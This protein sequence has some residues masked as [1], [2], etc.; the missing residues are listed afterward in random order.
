MMTSGEV[1]SNSTNP[2][3]DSR[4][5]CEAFEALTPIPSVLL[6]SAFRIVKVSASFLVLNHLTSDECLGANIY[7]L[8]KSRT[9]IPGPA[10]LQLVIDN[11]IALKNVYATSEHQAVGRFYADLRAVPIFEKDSLLYLLLEVR[12]RKTEN[13]PGCIINDQ[14]DTNETYRILVDTVKDYA[15]FMLDTEGKVRT[16]NAG[17]Q[18]LKGYKPEDIIGRHFSTF[19]GEEDIIS[20]K[21]RKELEI[22]LRDGKVEDEGWRYKKDGSKFWANVSLI[23]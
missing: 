17:A 5:I 8:V 23:F 21:P 19:Y 9:L 12:D 10:A 2:G 6:D 16:W 7:D 1:S 14:L 11:A 20:E 3:L 22:C 15:I 13:D 4:S 18:L